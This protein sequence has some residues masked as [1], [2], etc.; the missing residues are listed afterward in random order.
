MRHNAT[1]PSLI[2]DSGL[3]DKLKVFYRDI[4]TTPLDRIHH[5]YDK[6]II[7]KDP[8]HEIRGIDA[9]H[10]Y[11][12]TMCANVS[13]GRFEFLDQQVGNGNAFIK[14][15]MHFRHPKLGDELISVRGVS[16]LQFAE[17]IYY[18]EDIYDMGEMIYDHIPLLGA[19]T[20]W[21]KQRLTNS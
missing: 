4:P 2:I 5:I 21:L 1:D 6:D 20:R 17:R 16:H 19:C 18:H 9:M 15:N 14:W 10:A 3:I 13:E 11:M 12:L 7:F 8:V